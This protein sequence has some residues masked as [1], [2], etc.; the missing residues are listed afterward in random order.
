[1]EI[2]KL[3]RRA[4]SDE[5]QLGGVGPVGGLPDPSPRFIEPA[6]ELQR[7]AEVDEKREPLG[8]VGAKERHRP[9]QE[10][11]GRMAVSAGER[12]AR[13]GREA[14]GRFR[15]ERSGPLVERIEI[16]ER[17]GGLGEVVAGDL[18]HLEL[19]GGIGD[20]PGYALVKLCARKFRETRVGGVADEDVAEA[21][22]GFACA[23]LHA[24][25]DEFLPLELAQ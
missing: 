20:R 5:R 3:E 23:S 17:A 16:H 19:A 24:R 13:S 25:A 11:D 2:G 9:L 8:I 15:R 14:S 4:V 12:S 10:G 1:V 21:P 22:L 7:R 6:G 18:V